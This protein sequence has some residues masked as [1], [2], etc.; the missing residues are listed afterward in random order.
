MTKQITALLDAG[1]TDFWAAP[2]PVGADKKASRVRTHDLLKT[3]VALLQR[4]A[5]RVRD[6]RVIGDPLLT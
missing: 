3:L 6:F 1:V 4:P 5:V 2:F